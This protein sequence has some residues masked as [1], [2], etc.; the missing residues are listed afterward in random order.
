MNIWKRLSVVSLLAL[1]PSLIAGSKDLVE[2]AK[3]EAVWPEIW[4]Y[5]GLRGYGS[6]EHVAPNGLEFDPLFKSEFNF[7]LGLLPR[8]KLYLFLEGD[9]WGQR[10]APGVTNDSQGSYDFSKREFDVNAGLAWNPFFERLEVRAS[11][12]ARNNLNR[13]ISRTKASGYQDGVE[14][15]ARYYFCPGNINDR[16]RLNF[17]GLG[18]TPSQSL[19]GGDGSEFRAGLSARAYATYSIPALRSYLYADA[20]LIADE[21]V[22]LRLVSVDGGLAARPFRCLPNLEF[23]VGDEVIVDLEADTTRNLVYGAIRAYYGGLDGKSEELSG[24]TSAVPSGPEVWGNFGLGGYAIGDRMA[25]DGVPFE[26]IFR[27]EFNLNFGLLSRKRLYLF[28]ENEFWVQR[29]SAAGLNPRDPAN[30]DISQREFDLNAGLAWN[31]FDRFE[32]RT[33]A[34]A[35]N[36]LNRGGAV[37]KDPSKTFPAG[38]QDG[39]QLEGR[40]YFPSANIYDLG[41]LSFLGIGYYPSQTL[42]GGD[43]TGFHPGMFARASASYNIPKLRSYLFGDARFIAEKQVSM[44]LI[45]F[46]AGLAMRPFSR[47]DNL[48]FR[49]TL[50]TARFD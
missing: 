22:T 18:Y 50:S 2:D 41:R 3:T 11:G 49:V 7:N 5:I 29:S 19:I 47:L 46:N 33:S 26:P 28:V 17:I 31:V 8:K 37:A 24:R 20:K 32:L 27:S 6:G 38:Y 44:K 40:Y 10:A 13:G 9:F 45:T 35:L 21:N 15:E 39:I 42:I 16:G 36:N 14:L 43:G 12:Y 48:E 34:Y 30:D 4:G 25:P 1:A 23:R